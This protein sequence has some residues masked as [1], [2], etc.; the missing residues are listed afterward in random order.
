MEA[1]GSTTS[2]RLWCRV[3][4]SRRSSVRSFITTSAKAWK[5]GSSPRL[6]KI[7]QP[8][9]RTTRR[10]ASKRPKEK[11]RRS[12]TAMSSKKL[13]FASNLQY[14]LRFY[15]RE[16]LTHVFL[17]QVFDSRSVAGLALSIFRRLDD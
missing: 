8:L 1:V 5:R 12:A 3:V 6:V 11:G 4:T 15:A 17:L 9:R 2:R 14:G 13:F 10:L 16:R 7:S